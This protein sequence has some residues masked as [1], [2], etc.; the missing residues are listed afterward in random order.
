MEAEIKITITQLE[1]LLDQQ[2]EI[3]IERCMQNTSFYNSESTEGHMKSLPI[4][5]EK[6][7]KNGLTA[8]YPHDFT[9]LKKY[10]K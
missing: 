3:T 8:N 7:V 6:F 10:I 9:V 5:K 4:D 2:K 1:Y